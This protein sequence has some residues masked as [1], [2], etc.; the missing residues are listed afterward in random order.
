MSE[1]NTEYLRRYLADPET[2][3]GNNIYVNTGPPGPQGPPGIQGVQGVQGEKG[4]TGASSSVAFY[5]ADAQSTGQSDPGTAFIRWNNATQN[6]ATSLYFDI[7]TEDGFDV[8]LIFKLSNPND[9]FI[10]QDR[11]LSQNFQTWRMTGSV[12]NYPDWFEI[13]VEFVGIEGAEFNHNTRLAVLIQHQGQVGPPGPQGPQGESG[14]TVQLLD[15]G[16][17]VPIRTQWDFVGSGV[18]LN[19]NGA[20]TIINVSNLVVPTINVQTGTS[21]TLLST[22]NGNIITFNNA[23]AITL[24]VPAG[25]GSGYSVL[26]VQLG[27]GK[28]TVAGSGTT[29]IQRQS[30]IKTAG[31]SAV[32]SILAYGTNLFVLSGDLV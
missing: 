18:S 25:L 10:I 24:T 26:I 21:Y 11:D 14:V 32:A 31:Q 15:E 28:I 7:L 20:K 23:A 9:I 13:P 16:I 12:I 4:E 8:T 5:K 27:A 17:S 6:L 1:A 19:D 30:F 22:D 29:I 3:D 2:V